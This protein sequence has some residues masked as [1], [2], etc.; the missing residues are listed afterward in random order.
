MTSSMRA[1]PTPLVARLLAVALLTAGCSASETAAVDTAAPTTSSTSTTTSTT[2][3]TSTTTTSTTL[4]ELP[5]PLPPPPARAPEPEV[6]LGTIEIPAIGVSKNLYE[7][8]SLTT[9]D[10]G[11]GHWPGTAMPGQYGNVVIGGHRTSHDKPF[12]DVDQLVAGDE[13]IYTTADGRFVY[14][15]TEVF[16]IDPTEIWIIDQEPGYI[17]TLFACH[18]P[19]S[20]RQRIIVRA[21]L[22]DA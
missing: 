9:L 18:P 14:L 2:S 11:P 4:P 12:H 16:I 20:T 8:V 1:F 6:L 19:G 5:V 17:T 21:T 3:T 7:G 15:V 10:R 22:S 13:I